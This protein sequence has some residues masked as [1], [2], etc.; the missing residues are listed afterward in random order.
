MSTNYKI[1]T[2]LMLLSLVTIL[3]LQIKL[4]KRKELKI[5]DDVFP[6]LTISLWKR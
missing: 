3:M 4:I 2:I 1:V 5:W 6:I